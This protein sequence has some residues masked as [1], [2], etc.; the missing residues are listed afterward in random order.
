MISNIFDVIRRYTLKYPEVVKFRTMDC[1]SV[2]ILEAPD[3]QRSNIGPSMKLRI[4]QW[5][6]ELGKPWKNQPPTPTGSMGGL[7]STYLRGFWFV[8]EVISTKMLLWFCPFYDIGVLQ[9]LIKLVMVPHEILLNVVWQA[10][11]YCSITY[12]LPATGNWRPI[13]HS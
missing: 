7:Q 3:F 11:L 9:I 4:F 1:T 6:A 13:G 12:N 8:P 2:P 5:L 10:I